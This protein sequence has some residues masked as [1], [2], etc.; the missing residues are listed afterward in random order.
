ME[1]EAG[2]LSWD[3][4]FDGVVVGGVTVLGVFRPFRLLLVLVLLLRRPR[5]SLDGDRHVGVGDTGDDN[6]L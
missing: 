6:V 2:E 3:E 1:V 4:N 5:G